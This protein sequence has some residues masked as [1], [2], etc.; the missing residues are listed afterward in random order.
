ME[1][2]FAAWPALYMGLGGSF[3][4]YARRRRRAPRWM[5][6][7]G[8]EWAFRMVADPRRVQRLQ[9]CVRFAWLIVRGR[10]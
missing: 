7:L 2:L 3:D 5:R 4:I 6:R 8:I 1:Q 10:L 9:R